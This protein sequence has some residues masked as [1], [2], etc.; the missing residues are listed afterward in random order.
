MSDS[1][2]PKQYAA[3]RQAIIIKTITELRERHKLSQ[4]DLA[5]L[6]GCSPSRIA[7]LESDGHGEYGLGELEL[8]ALR[9]GQEPAQFLHLSSSDRS[10]LE[11]AYADSV[12][13]PAL[14][15]HLT[16]SLPPDVSLQIDIDL[17]L[18]WSSDGALLAGAVESEGPDKLWVSHSSGCHSLGQFRSHFQQSLG[19]D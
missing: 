6:L 10:R 1:V 18:A 17:E 12:T 2:T 9:F 4:R 16:C 3:E 7:R 8:L 15:Q 11:K 13:A 19:T 14:G 5:D